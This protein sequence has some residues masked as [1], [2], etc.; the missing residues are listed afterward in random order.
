MGL[1]AEPAK[2]L[3]RSARLDRALF[4]SGRR[5]FLLPYGYRIGYKMLVVFWRLS[6]EGLRT[7]QLSRDPNSRAI[8]PQ[9]GRRRGPGNPSRRRLACQSLEPLSEDWP[10]LPLD[11][12][13]S[14][15]RMVVKVIMG[16]RWP[17]VAVH[18]A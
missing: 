10:G 13:V 16:F 2:T 7:K 14:P 18:V 17:P 6:W 9:P 12:G 15:H 11:T 3:S 1:T 4:L 8:P 5:N